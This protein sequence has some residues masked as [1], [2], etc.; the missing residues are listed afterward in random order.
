MNNYP[1][2]P[3]S[4]DYAAEFGAIDPAPDTIA[5]TLTTVPGA[6]YTLSY[7]VSHSDS[8]SENEFQAS[9]NGAV[10]QDMIGANAFDWTN[11][12]F[13][14]TATSTA[15]ALQFSCLRSAGVVC[16]G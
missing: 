2:A 15:T 7:W 4:G 10:V 5:Q 12:T 9:W 16:P 1:I 11:Y 14:E 13:T 3:H 6:T 8:D